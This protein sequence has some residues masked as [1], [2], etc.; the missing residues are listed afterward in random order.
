MPAA[1][2]ARPSAANKLNNAMVKR[3]C[4]VWTPST[5][6][7]VAGRPEFAGRFI[8]DSNVVRSADLPF[9]RHAAA[10]EWN[11]ERAQIVGTDQ[12]QSYP[13][14]FGVGLALDRESG[15]RPAERQ[16]TDADR[17]GLRAGQ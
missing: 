8:D 1:A 10:Q 17:R 15:L 3:G 2:S 14:P 11:A 12:I 4:T 6:S 16:P 7:I 5:S 9:R 13:T